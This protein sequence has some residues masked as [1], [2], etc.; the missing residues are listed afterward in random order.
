MF[1]YKKNPQKLFLKTFLRSYLYWLD[2]LIGPVNS[3]INIFILYF[4]FS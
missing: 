4:V 3:T 1:S 2:Y